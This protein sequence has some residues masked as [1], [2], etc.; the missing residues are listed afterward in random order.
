[1][2]SELAGHWMLD[3][4]VDFLNHGSFGATPRPVLEAQRAWRDRMEAEPTRFF[5][6][7]LE[8]ALDGAR[9]RLAAF[10]GADAQ[11]VAW[12]PNA[13]AGFNTVLRSVRL[14]PGDELLTTDHAYNAARNAMEAVAVAAGARVVVAAVP[15]PLDDAG[16]VIE[17]VMDCV[18]A[19]T[20]L[21]LI[22][23]ATSATA[24]VF[25]IA[26]LVAALAGRG[27]ETLVDGAHGPGMVELALEQ[28][29][30]AYYTGNCH[31]WLCAPK[32]SAFLHVR[33]DLRDSVRPL[34]VSHGANSPRTDRSRFHL[35]FDWTGTADPS[36]YLSVPAAIDFIER[37]L[38]GGWP[39]AR[40]R[41]RRLALE[42]RDLL[43]AA[44]EVEPPTPDAMIGAMA[45]V[46]L[47]ATAEPYGVQGVD[48]YRDP[49]HEALLREHGIQVPLTPWPARP[50][51]GAWRRLIR[52]SAALYND[53][54]QY[55]RLARALPAALERLTAVD[56]NADRP[57]HARR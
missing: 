17:A 12:V 24:L 38:P 31:K 18:T 44:L 48:L 37:L 14:E 51:G 25:P 53:R 1:M 11:D 2:P 21:A 22:D 40:D 29:G 49:V 42:A 23:H 47:A 41:C 57:V 9:N 55:E 16:Q 19:R 20:R 36:A 33:R 34:V 56:D 39:E 45:S 26:E 6:E 8:P 15:F 28:L 46:P 54:A 32:G 4:A 50:D 52:I 43:C 30:A 10:V 5:A 3:P 27:V 13:T 35:E 7:E